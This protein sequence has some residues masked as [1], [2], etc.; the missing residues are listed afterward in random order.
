MSMQTLKVALKES[1]DSVDSVLEAPG[2]IQIEP[3][4]EGAMP[5]LMAGMNPKK[6]WATPPR[7]QMYAA[8]SSDQQPTATQPPS[9]VAGFFTRD[10]PPAQRPQP[11][12]ALAPAKEASMGIARFV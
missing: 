12:A 1:P 9:N 3:P 5:V 4:D 7:A 8:G 2:G 11:V 10:V 6:A